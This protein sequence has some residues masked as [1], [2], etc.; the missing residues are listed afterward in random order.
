MIL[1]HDLEKFFS[2][3]EEAMVDNAMEERGK[4]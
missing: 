1:I 4:N 3:E 2:L